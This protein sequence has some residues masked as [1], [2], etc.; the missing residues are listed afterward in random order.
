MK[1]KIKIFTICVLIIINILLCLYYP[2]LATIFVI[3]TASCIVF[4]YYYINIYAFEKRLKKN[5]EYLHEII[6]S[7][8]ISFVEECKDELEQVITY[9]S[10]RIYAGQAPEESLTRLE[11]EIANLLEGWNR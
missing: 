2:K 6:Y 7:L 1:T 5:V 10:K 4:L 9:C 3:A 11:K 8:P